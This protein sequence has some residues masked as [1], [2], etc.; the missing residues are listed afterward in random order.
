M[1]HVWG[2]SV[3][4]LIT[5][6]ELTLQPILLSFLFCSCTC[7]LL[8]HDLGLVLLHV[9]GAISEPASPGT[10]SGMILATKTQ[11]NHCKANLG[12]S[13]WGRVIV[14]TTIKVMKSRLEYEVRTIKR[15]K[16]RF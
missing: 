6:L 9:D 11:D 5:V 15:D 2:I 4:D 16:R 3:T 1:P 10:T 7:H 13:W 12:Y 8:G 14:F